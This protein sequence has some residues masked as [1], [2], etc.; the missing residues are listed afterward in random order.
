MQRIWPNTASSRSRAQLQDLQRSRLVA[1]VEDIV[2]LYV[3]PPEKAL[4]LSVDEK[5]QI[6]ALDRTQPGLPL[7]KGRAGTMTDDY[8]RNGTTTL[9]AALMWRPVPSSAKSGTPSGNEFLPFLKQSTVRRRTSIASDPRQLRHPQDAGREALVTRHRRFTLHFTPTSCSWLNL[10]ERLFAEITRQRIRRETFNDV[11]ELKTAIDE[12]IEHRN[13]NPKPFK[14]TA[15]AKSI[16][17][18]HRRPK[19]RS[20]SQKRDADEDQ[21]TSVGTMLPKFFG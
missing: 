5:S 6:Q 13:Q 18:K 7:K 21:N 15:S 12:W 20:P 16:L 17:A 14:W 11:T 10:V 8:K 3:D 19:K 2:G 9:F 4:V 1:K